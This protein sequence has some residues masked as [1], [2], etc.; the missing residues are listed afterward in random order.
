MTNRR[1]QFRRRLLVTTIVMLTGISLQ[2]LPSMLPVTV[3]AWWKPM[4]TL[5]IFCGAVAELL[6]VWSVCRHRN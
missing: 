4:A 3:P 1:G 6:A 5:T 2:I